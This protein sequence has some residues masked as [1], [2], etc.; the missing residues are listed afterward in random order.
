MVPAVCYN[1]SLNPQAIMLELLHR[2]TRYFPAS[3]PW[4]S[5]TRA[6]VLIAVFAV[7]IAALEW[8]AHR[9]LGR[10]RSAVF[11]NDIAY[12]LFY[13]GGIYNLLYLPV[14]AVLQKKFAFAN[15]H[16]LDA[17]PVPIAFV[18]F[19]VIAD[20]GEY[21][22]HRLHHASKYLWAFHSVH[23]A[24]TRLTFL[25]SNRNHLV[26]Q[27]VS[28]ALMFLPILILG[29]PRVVWMPFML[30]HIVLESLQHAELSWRYGPLYRVIVSP[31][32]HN[33]HHSTIATEYNG[34][35]AKILSFWD[36][37]FGTAVDRES[38][39]AAYGID[40]I[41]IAERLDA[42]LLA[43]FALLRRGVESA[44]APAAP[45]MATAEAP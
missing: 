25:M 5:L 9:D 2:V 28:N 6:A 45:A 42:Q 29:T 8:L 27:M 21:W 1:P 33:L 11:F 32:F 20:F 3:D 41:Q 22:I 18:A 35:Y 44:P 39:P 13:Q 37:V 17:L 43:P 12:T 19:W 31:L 7:G 40:G 15:L 26:E 10:Y 14:F 4:R 34:N 36:F 23:H 24:P 16:I 30:F 38:L